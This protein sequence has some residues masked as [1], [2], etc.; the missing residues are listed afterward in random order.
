MV[1][2]HN[3]K[4]IRSYVSKPTDLETFL[5]EILF[6]GRSNVGKSSLINLLTGSTK[7]AFVSSKPGHTKLLN[8]FNIDD[9]FFLVDAPGYGY[10][11]TNRSAD[12]AF[13]SI[14]N[15]YFE[16]NQNLKLVCLL[17]DSRREI[18]NDDFE[19]MEYFVHYD[20]PFFIIMTKTDKINQSIKSKLYKKVTDII[21][22]F[23][24]ENVFFTRKDKR[25]SLDKLKQSINDFL[26]IDNE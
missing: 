5:P 4:F 21:E 13:R 7:L 26:S 24:L 6:V 1:N 25:E 15:E 14:M 22:N 16:D 8:Y 2:F 20:I 19:I 18:T 12:K 9:K 11:A 10:S 23:D 3:A 17:L